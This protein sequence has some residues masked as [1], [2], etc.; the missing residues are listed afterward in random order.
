MVLAETIE[1]R[2]RTWKFERKGH[3]KMEVHL[4]LYSDSFGSC[5]RYQIEAFRLMMRMMKLTQNQESL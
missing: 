5:L 3:T 1:V 2:F 4:H